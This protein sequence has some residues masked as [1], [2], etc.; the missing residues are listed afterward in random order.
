MFYRALVIVYTA[1]ILK[2]AFPETFSAEKI[3]LSYI[4]ACLF[5]IFVVDVAISLWL[6]RRWEKV[7][8]KEKKRK[9]RKISFWMMTY[10]FVFPLLLRFV[11]EPIAERG[12]SIKYVA[13][14]V[15]YYFFVHFIP[16][17][18]EK[19]GEDD[20][21][22]NEEDKMIE[23]DIQ[24]LS[25]K[26]WYVS[27]K[28]ILILCFV[29]PPIGYVYVLLMRK[30]MTEKAKLVYVTLATIVMG[31]WTLK[32]LPPYLYV[33]TVFAMICFVFLGRYVR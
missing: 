6:Q 10:V 21:E 23:K 22:S 7:T 16:Y 32:F 24:E 2:Y 19:I 5:I 8:G 13:L 31:I 33:L 25:K 17:M 18:N 28:F 27:E 1:I 3:Q 4:A 20:E 29:T 14:M 30:E 26:K 12:I 11:S 9:K 15:F